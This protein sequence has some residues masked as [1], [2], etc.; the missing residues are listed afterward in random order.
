MNASEAD[1]DD[2]SDDGRKFDFLNKEP[3][4]KRTLCSCLTKYKL[5]H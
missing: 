4:Y 2:S 1:E 3:Q 5:S